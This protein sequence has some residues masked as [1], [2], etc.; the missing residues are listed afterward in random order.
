MQ[1]FTDMSFLI[2]LLFID[3]EWI[4]STQNLGKNFSLSKVDRNEAKIFTK[5]CLYIQNKPLDFKM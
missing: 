4:A 1:I 5:L 3:L 2:H